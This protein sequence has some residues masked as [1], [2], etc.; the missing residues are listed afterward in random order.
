MEWINESKKK[1]KK[2]LAINMSTLILFDSLDKPMDITDINK[3]GTV[4][5][6]AAISV[7]KKISTPL[8]S[9]PAGADIFC[10]EYPM[11]IRDL[12]ALGKRRRL[13]NKYKIANIA[14][15]PDLFFSIT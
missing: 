7:K 6:I 2:Q 11:A 3:S 13:K 4:L 10:I 14:T 1:I 15:P 8:G 9:L 12:T 5:I